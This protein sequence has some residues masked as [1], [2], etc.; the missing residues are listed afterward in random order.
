[1]YGAAEQRDALAHP[2]D[3]VPAFDNLTVARRCKR[4]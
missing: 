4:V 3:S 1:V 2:E